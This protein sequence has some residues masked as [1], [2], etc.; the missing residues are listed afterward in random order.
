MRIGINSRIC[1]EKSTGIPYYIQALYAHIL[2][3]DKLNSYFFFQTSNKKTIGKTYTI[4]LLDSRIGKILFDL[5]FVI[6]LIKKHHIDIFHGPA[7]IL[8]LI[9][10][11][12]VKYILTIHDLT[13]LIMPHIYHPLFG[14]YYKLAVKRATSLAD[15]I[16]AD[17]ENTM[18]DFLRF[19]P[20]ARSKI[21]VLYPGVKDFFLTNTRRQLSPHYPFKYFFCL[22]THDKRKNTNVLLEVM[23]MYSS[24][25]CRYKLI[26]AG[27]LS[28]TYRSELMHKIKIYDLSQT[29][30]LMDFVG[31]DELKSLYQQA[32]LFIYPSLYEGFGLPVVE[33]IA[34]GCIPA[35]SDNSS[36]GE[37]VTDQRLRFDPQNTDSIYKVISFILSL[38]KE[39]KENLTK[40]QKRHL[41]KFNWDKSAG[42]LVDHF[43]KLH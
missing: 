27:K 22:A 33:A 2:K 10:P 30:M 6:F 39:E 41:Q 23:R 34:C 8:P 3:I 25:L 7:H 1:T 19:Y 5:I 12:G 43:Y 17:S 28:E 38:S 4:P 36:L 42:L 31:E 40:K 24:D 13:F 29:V 9:K 14:I 11:R 35:V 21:L 37:I 16:V 15:L 32:E 18:R 26:V 20:T